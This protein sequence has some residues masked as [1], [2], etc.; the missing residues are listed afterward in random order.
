MRPGS[1]F[2]NITQSEGIVTLDIPTG[3]VAE[4]HLHATLHFLSIFTAH[5]LFLRA[6]PFDNGKSNSLKRFKF[7]LRYVDWRF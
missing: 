4:I 2:I 6:A 3:K 5:S 1:V 7:L